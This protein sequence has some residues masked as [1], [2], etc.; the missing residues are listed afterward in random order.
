LAGVQD[1]AD[2]KDDD[3]GVGNGFVDVFNPDGTMSSRFASNGKLNSPWAIALAPTGFGTFSGDI[4]VGNF[5]DGQIGAYDPATGTFIDFLRTDAGDPISIDG[6][7]GLVV[8]PAAQPSTL[9]F[10]AGP[11]DEATGLLG[12]IKVK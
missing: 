1:V 10:S 2:A 11:N 8:G 3:P 7:W 4:L 5:G 6:L 9:F 12:T